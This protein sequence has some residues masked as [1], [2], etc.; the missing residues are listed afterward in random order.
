MPAPSVIVGAALGVPND[1]DFIVGLSLVGGADLIGTGYSTVTDG[2]ELVTVQRGRWSQVTD[3]IDAGDMTVQF[4]N[5]DRAF[6][7]THVTSPYYG[8]VRPGVAV[9]VQ[10]QADGFDA[11]T[12]MTGEADGVELEY[13]VDGRS[14]TIFRCT[15]GLGQLGAS[16]F[17][18]WT[19]SGTTAG[20]KLTAIC[21]R[22]EVAWPAPLRDFDEGIA[23]LQSDSVSWG[24]NALNYAQLIAR[25]ELGYLFTSADGVL[26]FRTRNVSATVSPSVSFGGSGIA[27]QGIA[28][29]YGEFLFSRVGVDREAGVSQTVQVADLSSWREMNGSPRTLRLS[30]LLLS[31]D[32]QSLA[33]AEYLLETYST[34]RYQVSEITVELA[35]LSAADQ[36]AVLSLDL[37]DVVSVEFTPNDTGAAISQTLLVQGI[38]HDLTPASHVVRL[39][40]IA[41]AV[42][43]FIVGSSLVGGS[44]VVAF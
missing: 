20:A 19:S 38:A 2:A 12:L 16:E 17:D 42:D 30:N 35:A 25:S 22:S 28:A 44:D 43:L 13:D 27:F 40:L 14:V 9:R 10:A 1:G 24:S 11:R 3:V 4:L 23:T 26:T 15:D 36:D 5:L 6:D 41:A 39:S 8:R 31:S 34:P 21:E 33:L 7:P 37:T 29:K 32:A 18:A